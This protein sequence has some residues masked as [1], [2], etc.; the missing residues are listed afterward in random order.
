ME[1][2]VAHYYANANEWAEQDGVVYY[3]ESTDQQGKSWLGIEAQQH[4]VMMFAQRYHIRIVKEFTE[5]ISTRRKRRPKLE[6]ALK[7]AKDNKAVLIIAVLD[8]LARSV[9]FISALMESNIRFIIADR[10]YATRF[11]L[12][13][14]AAT[15][16]EERRRTSIRTTKCLAAAKRRGVV[17][18]K[19]GKEVLSKKNAAT[20]ASFTLQIRPVIEQIKGEG[21]TTVR[22]ITEQLS[23]R[24]IQTYRGGKWHVTGVQRLLVRLRNIPM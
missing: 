22:G 6:E 15:A 16:E 4:D 8:R 23:L 3:R 20:A 24:N 18:G 9:A 21:F 2:D 12:H 17:L 1:Y 5:I 7:Y 11:E 13:I 14:N 10:P 19:Y